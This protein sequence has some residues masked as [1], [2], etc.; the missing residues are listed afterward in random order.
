MAKGLEFCVMSH[1]DGGELRFFFMHL[2]IFVPVFHSQSLE[3]QSSSIVMG[4]V[5]LP[6]VPGDVN[7]PD[8]VHL[9]LNFNSYNILRKKLDNLAY[10]A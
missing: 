6:R 5:I 9:N 8:V 2:S 1:H 4:E 7:T 3:K 10:A